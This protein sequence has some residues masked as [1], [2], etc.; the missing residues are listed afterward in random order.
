MRRGTAEAVI[1]QAN[2]W[3]GFTEGPDNTQPFG[4]WDGLPH[5]AWCG[6]FV[7]YCLAKAGVAGDW[8]G[9][10]SQRYT[11][12]AAT[13]WKVKGRWRQSPRR[14]DLVFFAWGDGGDW[15]DHIGIVTGVGDWDARGVVATIEGNAQPPGGG[16]QGVFRHRRDRSVIAGF[17]RPKYGPTGPKR[18]WRQGDTGPMVKRIQQKLNV[19][20]DGEFGPKTKAALL[21][22]QRDRWPARNGVAGPRTLKALGIRL[23]RRRH[24]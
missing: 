10:D 20:V 23:P 9:T 4:E 18:S 24:R 21:A 12:A 15:I 16:T 2:D 6:Q 8:R 11:P 13:R 7:S 19:T 5:G 1:D 22:W 17:A 3:L 14:G